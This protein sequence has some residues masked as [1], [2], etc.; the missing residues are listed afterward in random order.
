MP[1]VACL[2]PTC[3]LSGAV[4]GHIL[5]R[6]ILLA[7]HAHPRRKIVVTCVAVTIQML[8]LEQVDHGRTV[9]ESDFVL[10]GRKIYVR[11]LFMS[12]LVFPY[13]PVLRPRHPH[14]KFSARGARACPT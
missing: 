6:L 10:A 11:L 7:K 1:D 14:R 5:L 8:L 2:L 12:T 3:S 13:H 4:Q 9:T